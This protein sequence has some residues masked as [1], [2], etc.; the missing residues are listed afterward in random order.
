MGKITKYTLGRGEVHFAQFLPDT[1][2]PGG[3][4]YLG[5]SPELSF[6]VESDALEH[7]NSDR[8]INEMDASMTLK[9]TRSGQIVTDEILAE[10]L[11]LFLFGNSDTTTVAGGAVV[12]EVIAGVSLDR[13]YTLGVSDSDPIGVL[14]V[15]YPGTGG[16]LFSVKNSAGSTTYV[17]GDDYVWNETSGLLTPLSGGAITE[18]Q[19]IKVSYTELAYNYERIVSAGEP[20]SGALKFIA[21]NPAGPS[22]NWLLP[23]V[24]VSPNGDLNMKGDDWQKLPFK[25]QILRKGALEAIY[26]NGTPFTP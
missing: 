21:Y 15:A 2:T 13:G 26:V 6:N 20:I 19:D 8:F 25:F 10:N 5:N 12:D 9:T 24:V 17:A 18:G 7:Y 4:R 1:Q 16:T 14:K 23:W 11:A 22:R 3:Y